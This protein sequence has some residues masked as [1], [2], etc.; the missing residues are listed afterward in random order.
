MTKIYLV[1]SSKGCFEDFREYR[2]VAFTSEEETH[3]FIAA[4]EALQEA[5]SKFQDS[6]EGLTLQV[7]DPAAM[8]IE[9]GKWKVLDPDMDYDTEYQFFELALH[10]E[11]VAPER[12]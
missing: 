2:L 10:E 11:F 12:N 6:P 9:R 1:T 7:R 3:K 5:W 8:E 4:A